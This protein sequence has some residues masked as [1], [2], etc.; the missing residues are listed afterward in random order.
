[1]LKSKE[2]REKSK[3]TKYKKNPIFLCKSFQKSYVSK[4]DCNETCFSE[5][6]WFLV[7]NTMLKNYFFVACLELLHELRISPLIKDGPFL[8]IRF[9]QVH[10]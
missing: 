9:R 5:N 4:F 8:N 2:L 1:M 3:S 6:L 10:L 7:K